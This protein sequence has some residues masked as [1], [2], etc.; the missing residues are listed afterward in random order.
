[1]ALR[2]LGEATDWA[3]LYRVE[4]RTGF[5]KHG[6]VTVAK[7][8]HVFLFSITVCDGYMRNQASM[9]DRPDADCVSDRVFWNLGSLLSKIRIHQ[10]MGL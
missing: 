3:R 2:G 8:A 6:E 4:S 5:G 10:G 1:M 7:I 9:V